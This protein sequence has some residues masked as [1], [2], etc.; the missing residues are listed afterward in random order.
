[1]NIT[2]QHWIALAVFAPIFWTSMAVLAHYQTKPLIERAVKQLQQARNL[3]ES[4]MGQG[5]NFVAMPAGV[6]TLAEIRADRGE[7]VHGFVLMVTGAI[8]GEHRNAYAAIIRDRVDEAMSAIERDSAGAVEL[9]GLML[10]V[11]TADKYIKEGLPNSGA[12]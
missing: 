10:R 5:A 9:T 11:E 6:R 2:A 4:A 7:S 12:H 8:T 1:M 3:K